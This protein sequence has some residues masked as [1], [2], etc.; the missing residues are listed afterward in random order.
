VLE[1]SENWPRI[2]QAVQTRQI[3]EVAAE[4]GV[5]PGEITAALIRA[6][7][8]RKAVPAPGIVPEVAPEVVEKPPAPVKSPEAIAA[9]K[10]AAEARR[11]AKAEAARQAE[12]R[13]ADLYVEAA[14]ALSRAELPDVEEDVL[15]PPPPPKPRRPRPK[16]APA[17]DAGVD[18]VATPDLAPPAPAPFVAPAVVAPPVAA[19]PPAAAPPAAA[20]P[21]SAD[22]A[23]SDAG[24][25]GFD[26]FGDG[27]K[28]SRIEPYRH[29]LT[30]HP[31]SHVARLAGVGVNAVAAYRRRHGFG[32][33]QGGPAAA[34]AARA[35]KLAAARAAAAAELA[36]AAEA[37]A[38]V[39][40]VAPAAVAPVVSP[41]VAVVAPAAVPVVPSAPIAAPVPAAAVAPPAEPALVAPP[42]APEVAPAPAP[43]EPA[44]VVAPEPVAAPAPAPV[45][46]VP[47]R[48]GN[49]GRRVFTVAMVDGST[50]YVVGG[51]WAE[52]AFALG[53]R[54]DVLSMTVLGALLE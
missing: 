2:L 45:V 42:P 8:T 12:A 36:A 30:V 29:L 44:A 37:A 16:P 9:A 21:E 38:G 27:R 14:A 46:P 52:A 7:V 31:D 25:D 11:A 18:A 17:V 19:A 47:N 39:A 32:P 24:F 15:P 22:G 23:D 50:A 10:A 49:K 48:S 28:P 20:P 34:R 3:R 4:F 53:D 6:N 54:Q 35:E 5:R 51:T 13:A 43:V 33:Y 26:E 40:P 41:A 1:Q